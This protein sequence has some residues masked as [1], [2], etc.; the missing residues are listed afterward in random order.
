MEDIQTILNEHDLSLKELH[1][2]DDLVAILYPKA[3]EITDRMR[4]HL[5][6][7]VFFE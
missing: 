2:F 5:M 6:M 3:D 4:N 1:S 7:D